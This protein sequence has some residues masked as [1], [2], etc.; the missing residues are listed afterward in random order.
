[1]QHNRF[2]SLNG[3]LVPEEKL[4]VSGRDI[5]LLRGYGVFDFLITYQG[6]KPFHLRDHLRRLYH[7][8]SLI[9][10][11]IPYAPSTL[12][13][14]VE[15][16]IA[17]NQWLSEKSIRIVVTGGVGPDAIT[18]SLENPTVLVVIDPLHTYPDEYYQEGVGVITSNFTRYEPSSK[19][20]NY[21]DAVRKLKRARNEGAIEVVYHDEALVFEGA[22]SNIFA[23]L[24]GELRTPKTGILPGITAQVLLEILDLEIS[25]KTVDFSISDLLRADEVFLSASNKEIMPVTKINGQPVGNGKVGP[26]TNEVMK[27]FRAYTYSTAWHGR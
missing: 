8:A 27:Q 11:D 19:S 15:E 4:L 18:A 22:T 16:A 9:E 10:L 5:G 17:A 13:G 12:F 7:S 23:V 24:D 1:M 2:H 14:W 26:I 21:L 20:L 25:L 6:G 3:M